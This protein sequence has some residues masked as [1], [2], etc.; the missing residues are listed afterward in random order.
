MRTLYDLLDV[1]S[2][3]DDEALRKAYH[4]AAKAHHPDL[5][6]RDPDATRRF[7]QVATAIGILRNPE[8]RAAYDR[9]LDR[10]RRQRRSRR[11]RI[12]IAYTLTAAALTVALVG[13]HALIG[14]VSTSTIVSKVENRAVPAPVAEAGEQRTQRTEPPEAA[15]RDAALA[16]EQE[17]RVPAAGHERRKTEREAALRLRE[18]HKTRQLAAIT[19]AARSATPTRSQAVHGAQTASPAASPRSFGR[20]EIAA[21][22]AFARF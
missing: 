15:E 10:E 3:A 1:H 8:Q 17:E 19:E 18:E 7:G 11:R 21:M 9:L 6:A 14:H 4:R 20:V 16:R 2:D 13:G 12:V 5:N 22:R